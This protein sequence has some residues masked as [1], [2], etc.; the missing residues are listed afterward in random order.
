MTLPMPLSKK[1]DDGAVQE[2]FWLT[3]KFAYEWAR[4][5]V[6]DQEGPVGPPGSWP[7]PGADGQPT[8]SVVATRVGA[9]A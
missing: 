2:L 6:V 4:V 1:P 9:T 3:W 8:R 5:V 7:L